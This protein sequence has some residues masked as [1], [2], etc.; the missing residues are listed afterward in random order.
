MSDAGIRPKPSID[1]W[2]K[3][4]WD[5]CKEQ[6]LELP[7]CDETG[8][9]FYPPAPVSPFTGKPT[10]SW[11]PVSGRGTIWS[12]V[13]FHRKYF[14]EFAEEI[15][16]TVAMVQLD[17]GPFLLTNI[18]GG[19]PEIGQRVEAVFEPFN[20]DWQLPLFALAGNEQ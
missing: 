20:G 15:P 2:S 9:F 7:R 10:V 18:R 6:R 13:V 5:A 3:P 4:F 11:A 16:Y 8:R 12:F 19:A 1:N 14:S 17:E